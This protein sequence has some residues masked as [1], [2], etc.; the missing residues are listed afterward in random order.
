MKLG[1]IGEN[2][3]EGV[4][5]DSQFAKEHGY[6]GL[7]YNYWGDFRDLTADTVT[8]MR[9]IHRKHGVR[10]CMLG[11]WGWNYLSPNAKERAEAHKMLDRAIT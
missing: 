10:V 2:S 3:L 11:I 9:A 7:E 8:K 5:Q 6:E 4:A 1:F